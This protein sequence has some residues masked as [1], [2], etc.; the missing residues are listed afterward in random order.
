MSI[1]DTAYD[2]RDTATSFD[3]AEIRFVCLGGRIDRTI[4]YSTRPAYLFFEATYDASTN[5]TFLRLK[6]GLY[7]YKPVRTRRRCIVCVGVPAE[8][9]AV[10]LV[11]AVTDKPLSDQVCALTER[12]SCLYF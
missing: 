12:P 4:V 3:P 8:G 1:E 11:D 6:V 5:W 7:A 10:R 9:F 2:W